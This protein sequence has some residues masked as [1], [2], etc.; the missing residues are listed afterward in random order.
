MGLHMVPVTVAKVHLQVAKQSLGP[1][2][3]WIVCP[4]A[5][6][7]YLGLRLFRQEALYSTRL[8]FFRL[9]RIVFDAELPFANTTRFERAFRLMFQTLTT[10]TTTTQEQQQLNHQTFSTILTLTL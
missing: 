2:V 7:L 5:L 6:K 8:F 1:V 3:G 9:G 10:A 4:L